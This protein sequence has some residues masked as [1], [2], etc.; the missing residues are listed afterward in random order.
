MSAP[1]QIRVQGRYRVGSL[2]FV[3]LEDDSLTLRSR[4]GSSYIVE[5]RCER[6]R[7]GHFCLPGREYGRLGGLGQV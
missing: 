4:V 2:V 1:V 3:D 5:V 6:Y 7:V